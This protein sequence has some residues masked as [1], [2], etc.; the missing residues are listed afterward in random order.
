M[1]MP[2]FL[3]CDNT[4]FEDD[5]FILHTEY[6]RF[7]M[8]YATQQIEMFEEVDPDEDPAELEAVMA[9]VMG[10]ME[11]FYDREVKRYEEGL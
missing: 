1:K 3:M 2:K 8:N 7:M 9:E 10:Q 5:I 4:D 6:P 11:N